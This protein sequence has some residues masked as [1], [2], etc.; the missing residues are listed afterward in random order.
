VL[1]SDDS[2]VIQIPFSTSCAS[3][4]SNG[5]DILNDESEGPAESVYLKEGHCPG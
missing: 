4:V 5:K 2:S 3:V 1:V